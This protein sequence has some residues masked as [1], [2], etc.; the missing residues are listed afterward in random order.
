MEAKHSYSHEEIHAYSQL[1]NTMLLN[2]K[3]LED[4]L[5]LDSASENI[6]DKLDD[7]ILL[8]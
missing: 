3:G 4:Y 1:I 6:F 5:P 7:G 8:A 2:E